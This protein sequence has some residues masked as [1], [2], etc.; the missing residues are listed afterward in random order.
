MSSE[1]VNRPLRT[2]QGEAQKST[3]GRENNRVTYWFIGVVLVVLSLVLGFSF[4]GP[5][6]ASRTGVADGPA[7]SSTSQTTGGPSTDAAG[8]Q[9][10]PQAGTNSSASDPSNSRTGTAPQAPDSATPPG[11]ESVGAQ[12]GSQPNPALLERNGAGGSLSAVPPEAISP[13]STTPAAPPAS[14]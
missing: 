4:L 11:R 14:R 5:E 12:V 10:A 9:H 8:M 1:Q 13:A 6:G 7:T 2:P 3:S